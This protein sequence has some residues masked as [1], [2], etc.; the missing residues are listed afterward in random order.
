MA[1]SAKVTITLGRSGQVVKRRTISDIGIDDELPLSGRKRPVRERLG[2]TVVDPDSYGSKQGNKRRQTE[3]SSLQIGDDG[4]VEVR[5]I[6]RHDLRLKLMRKGLSKKS[7]SET[8]QNGVDLREKLSRNSK[9]LQGYEARGRVPESRSSYDVREVPESGSGYGSRGRVPESR[10]STLASQLPSARCADDLIKFDSSGKPYSSWTAGGLRHSSPDNLP[11]VRRDLSP[12][13]SVRR[14]MSPPRSVRRGMSPPRRGMSPPRSVQRG[15]SPPRSVRRGLSPPRS[16]RRGSSPP[17][18]VRRGISP[19][20]SVRR[21]M[22]PPRTYDQARSIPPPGSVGATR[23]SS[24]IARDVPDT[25]RTHQPYE[26]NSTIL[27]DTVQPAN[28]ISS[29]G[30]RLPMDTVLTEVPLTVTGLLKSLGLEKYVCLF[31]GEE[32]DMTALSQMKD[33]DLKDMGVPMGPRKKILQAAAPY[34]KQWQ[35]CPMI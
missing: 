35:R 23:S 16:G 5:Q 25:L 21:G 10:A 27:L 34:A 28:G 17:R 20:R 1:S 11:S 6:G 32:V 14:G 19:P 7:N 2:N 3:S 18:S 30:A 12:P 26:G 29:S 22:S 15:M 8:E 33:G 4:L 31:Q 13:R 9:N 24:H